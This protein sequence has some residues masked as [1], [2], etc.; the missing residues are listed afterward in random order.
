MAFTEKRR[1]YV[2][3]NMSDVFPTIKVLSHNRFKFLIQN[4]RSP[5]D[6]VS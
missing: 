2:F 1:A 3:C 6:A 5:Q 4:Y